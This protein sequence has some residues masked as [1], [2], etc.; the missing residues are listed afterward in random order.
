MTRLGTHPYKARK[1]MAGGK[2]SK[3]SVLLEEYQQLGNT[4]NE[5][6]KEDIAKGKVNE[7]GFTK[8]Q[9]KAI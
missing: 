5:V 9:M 8:E 4:Y 7:V 2:G 1:I 6:Y 3:D